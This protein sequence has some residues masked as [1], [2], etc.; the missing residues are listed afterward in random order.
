M[1]PE[2][3]AELVSRWVRLYTG[4]V[5]APLAR[6]RIE[7]VDA[8][9]HDHIAHER[10]AGTGDRRIA[11]SIAVR[12]LRG[13][14]ADVS[15]RWTVARA[16]RTS[17]ANQPRSAV[18]SIVRVALVT[19]FVLLVPLVGMQISGEVNWSA[20]DF[21]FA[22]ALLT[23]SGLLLELAARKPGNV[24]YR[25]GAAA[26]GVAAV[27]LGELD[28]APGLVLFGFLLIAGT[29]ALTIRRRQRSE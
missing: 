1:R 10:A 21:A 7:E 22:G 26:I 4:G 27:A 17:E 14:V 3:V 6:R 25:A 29:A 16:A 5:N 8:D 24:A 12:M 2:L 9:L 13:V 23:G 19:V 11:L 28:D 15:W 18:R 20:L